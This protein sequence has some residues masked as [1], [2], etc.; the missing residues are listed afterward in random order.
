[1]YMYDEWK[2]T[3]ECASSSSQY[4]EIKKKERKE[5]KEKQVKKERKVE[6]PILA[7]FQNIPSNLKN[8]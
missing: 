5:K 7:H 3:W 4:T 1:M 2:V 6:L 8:K